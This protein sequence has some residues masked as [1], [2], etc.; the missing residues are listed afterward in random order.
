M[1][2]MTKGVDY[3]GVAVVPFLHDGNGKYLVG[4]RTDKC[5]DEHFTWEPL[6]SGGLRFGETIE[7]AIAREVQEETGGRPFA[8]EYLGLREVF[9]EH[10]GK[11]THWLAFD[12]RAQIDPIA[13]SIKEPEKC[14]EIRWC[15]IEELPTPKHSQFPLFLQRYKD[16]L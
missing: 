16:R 1:L 3:I 6:G 11:K 9:R 4:L 2:D 5:R 12:Y 15:T 7:E 10:Q 13:V 14:K 8:F